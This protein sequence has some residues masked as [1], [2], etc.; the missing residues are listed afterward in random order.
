MRNFV[1][2]S[3]DMST[4]HHQHQQHIADLR[5]DYKLKALNEADVA[6]DPFAQFGHWWHDVMDSKI[7]EPNAMTVATAN[8]QGIPAARICL[9]KGYDTN[10]FVFFTNYNSHKGQDLAANPHA[11][12]VFF[13]KELER[14]VCIEGRVEK[15][16]DAEN[17]AYF[18]SRPAGSRI[19]AWSSPQSQV[20]ESRKVIEQNYLQY[21]EQYGTENIPR[22]PHWGGFVVKPHTV[23]FWQGRSSRMHDRI[24]Y[25]L[26]ADGSWKI[27]RLAP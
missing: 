12:L 7:D 3:R 24:R 9:L 15:L 10:G 8:T 1:I 25:T 5:R 16:S 6:S 27:E 26:Q 4:H 21:E 18:F 17:D 23:E 19:G 13:W 11:S 20:I 22:P 2:Q 14:Q